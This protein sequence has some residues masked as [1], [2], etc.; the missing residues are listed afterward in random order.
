MAQQVQF[1]QAPPPKRR[2]DSESSRRREER[3]SRSAREPERVFPDPKLGLTTAQAAS[4]LEQGLGNE[5]VESSAK[6]RD[7]SSGRIR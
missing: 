1:Q 5:M 6:P 4:F 3:A 7:R 2:R